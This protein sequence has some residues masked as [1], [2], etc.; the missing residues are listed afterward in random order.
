MRLRPA[1]ISLALTVAISLA[2]V[3]PWLAAAEDNAAPG[4]VA[5]MKGHTEAV[6]SVAFTPDGKYVVSGSGDHTLKVWDSV[7]GKEIKS[8]GGPAGHQNLVMSVAISPDGNLIASGG[9]DNT[10]K[11]W[12]FPSSTPL[13]ALA[14]SEG[15]S[16]LAVSPDGAKLAGGDKDGHVKIWNSADG[17]ELFQLN[18]HRGPITGLAFGGNGQFLISCGKDKTLRFWNL[19]NG[20][21]LGVIGAH[22]TEVRGLAVSPNNNAIFS[23]GADGS[24]KFWALPPVASNTLG[25]AY[26]DAVTALALS[27][28]GNAFITGSSDKSV[29]LVNATNGQ[30]I[31]EFK[32]ASAGVESVALSPNGAWIAAGT[33]D[34]RTLIW[35]TNDGQLLASVPSPA[36]GV[37]FQPNSNQ[38]LTGGSDGSLRLW[39]MPPAPERIVT[40]PDAVRTAIVSADG[41]R[42]FTGGADKIVRAW[43]LP[44]A[45]TPERQYSG[46]TAAVNA[47]ALSAD[48]KFLASAGDD[49]TIRFWNQ[50]NGQQTALIGAHTGPVTSLAFH[51]SGQVLSA[52]ADGSIKLWQQPGEGKLLAHPGQVASAVLSPDGSRLLTGC[53][54]KQVRLWNLSNG[55]IERPFAGPSLGVLCVAM[56]SAGTQVAAGS[57]D[58]TLFVWNTADAKEVRKFTLAAAVNS[59]AFSPDGKLLAGGLAD[60]SIH[61]FDLAM[62]REIKT[63]TGHSGAVHALH[64]TNK[65]DHLVSASADKSVQIWNIA[66]GKSVIKLEHA[67]SVRALA[68]NKDGTRIAA[69]GADKT[70]KV[71]TLAGQT[72]ITTPAEV[73]SVCFSPDE[74]R[75]LVGCADNKAR[76]YGNDGQFVEF[77]PHEGPV[78]A[79]AFHSDGKR[80]F[81]ASADK[82]ARMWPLSQVWQARHAGPVRQ[83]LFNGQFNRIIS[84]ADDKTIKIWNAAD[85]KLVKS[86]DAH[87]GPVTG[88]AVNADATRIV[89][90]GADKTVKIFNLPADPGAK[91]DKP[92]LINLPAIASAVSLSPNSQRIVAAV[93]REKTSKVHVFDANGK[94]LAVSAEH[95]GTVPSLS[96]LADNRTL[97][98]A[99]ADKIVRL[100]DVN[101]L[102][103]FDAHAGG[104]TSVAFHGN[105]SLAVSGGADKTVKLW[106][107]S[108]QPG[109][110][111]TGR[112]VKTFG[113]L[114]QAVRV[115]AFNRAGTQIAAA[116][117]KT[118]IVWNV[119]DGKEVRKLEH[120]AEVAGLSFSADGT[121]LATGAADNE[122]R[123]W[124][125]ATGLELQA[126]L[127]TGP[128]RAVVAHPG[129]NALLFSGSADKTVALHTTTVMRVL[130]TGAPLRSMTITPNGSHVVTAGEDGKIK[131]WNTGNGANERTVDGGK[132]IQALSLSKN[133][134]LLAAGGSDRIV[135]LFT[136]NDGRPLAEIKAPGI[137]R[138]LN[139]APNSQM[140]AVSCATPEGAGV[141]Q[142]WNVVFNPGQA[143]PA[144]FG[145]PV[146]TYSEAGSVGSIVFDNNGNNF[147]SGSDNKPVQ[148]WKLAADTPV[149]NFGH[150][151]L[152]DVVAFN[153]AGT[154]LAT[155]CH[156][157]RVRL[158][159]VAKGNQVREIQ[160][161]VT[162]PQPSSV[163]C[164]AWSRD[165]KQLISGSFDRSL[166]MWNADDGKLIR[167]FKGYEDKKFEKGHRAS[168]VTAALAPDGKTLASGDWDHA[169]KIWNVAD[170]SVLR[171]LTNPQLKAGAGQPPPQAHPGVVYSVRYTPDGQR[172]ISAGAAPRLR[173]YLA[174][175]NAADGKMLYGSEQS[176]GTLFSLAVS[177]DGKYLAVGAG[178]SGSGGE[179]GNKN[180]VYVMKLPSK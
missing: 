78:H 74:S 146:Q 6:Y 25:S 140:L 80:V 86:I 23:A 72:T 31:R 50:S 51:N 97:V 141:L 169:I 171:E 38:L 163:Y 87:N 98:S 35:Q 10:A 32:G 154:L 137:V 99:G 147:Y 107:I 29:R 132:D 73:L 95:G 100:S 69:G 173:S 120:P 46:H 55:Q 12:D 48:G 49:E 131:L 84:C 57:V 18:G 121:R 2:V 94:E 44:D 150:P 152:V 5:T 176:L 90:C 81:T 167:E 77:F 11:V 130:S 68:L 92:I 153:P 33:A 60:N 36:A 129:N 70:V 114:P 19:T 101:I 125:L 88:I 174:I 41:K 106:E 62:G 37:A 4:V 175:W 112:V 27:G 126:F 53:S 39:A 85:G 79:V 16:I 21:S 149:K 168:V 157:G 13:R 119:A 24:L 3:L 111:V 110:P 93:V 172:L 83:A 56:N 17:K 14:K 91:E 155:G 122:V 164:L 123:V 128:V 7:T 136:L 159:D 96:F 161:H 61:I 177:A 58:K 180:N 65:S 45:K 15:A 139:F 75:L 145:K 115:V 47:V 9:T 133:N 8:F 59:V 124:E 165:G 158:F 178:G 66:D 104:V 170:G 26:G 143:L 166:K 20:Q 118:A 108:N 135:R 67:G 151:N 103:S 162:M 1:S 54:D 52:S 148:V 30:L 117:G 89:S 43:N 144:E 116:A 71:W 156:D 102:A 142:T 42:M 105:G 109:A 82:T 134:V 34:K 28:D 22:T 160:A 64:F 76:V 179:E 113:P 127:H 40:H 63:I 138:N